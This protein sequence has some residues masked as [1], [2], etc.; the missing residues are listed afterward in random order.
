M[1][2]KP[3]V[4]VVD[5]DQVIATT[6]SMILNAAG[7]DSFAAFNADQA[8]DLAQAEKFD[9]LLT[10]VFM[11]PMNG[12]ELAIAFIQIQPAAHVLLFSGTPESARVTFE[13]SQCGH[14]FPLL[15]K[16]LHPSDLIQQLRAVSI[17]EGSQVL[18]R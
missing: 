14:D 16:P 9:V 3:R 18:S 7:F 5:D 11:L 6:T 4:L 17:P 13:A 2:N 8:L 1:P 12:I 15:Q 10:D